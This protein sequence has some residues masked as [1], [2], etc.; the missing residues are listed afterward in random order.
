MALGLELHAPDI[1]ERAG[2]MKLQPSGFPLSP[3]MLG[4]HFFKSFVVDT[5][6][7]KHE[8]HDTLARLFTVLNHQANLCL[9]L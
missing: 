4:F 6:F 1:E 5:V 9:K 2:H 7:W 8:M 3:L